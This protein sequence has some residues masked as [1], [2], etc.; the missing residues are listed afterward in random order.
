MKKEMAAKNKM[1]VDPAAVMRVSPSLPADGNSPS[2]EA[3]WWSQVA[4][5]ITRDVAMAIKD[6][7][8]NSTSVTDSPIKNL[9]SLDIPEDFSPPTGVTGGAS[10]AAA[11]GRGAID[12]SAEPTA[13]PASGGLPDPT[14]PIP[15]GPPT[16]PT[17]RVS[18]NLYDVVDFKMTLD[19][20]SDKVDLFLKTLATN[21]F[22]TVTRVEM[23]PVDSQLKQIQWYVYGTH[24]VVTLD[25]D[26]E[27]LF[28]R[29]WT[30][31]WMPSS[32]RK[33]LG[34]PDVA[35]GGKTAS[36]N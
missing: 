34:I 18:T 6:V 26:C 28:M 12:P 5:W 9:I 31:K 35:A 23:N 24:P 14:I 11:G 19:I 33:A 7:N 32:L 2:K 21:R 36:V 27:A 30:I 13:T 8:A 22:I 1:Y 25:L 15:D 4:F 3:I 10:A 16:V 17:R 29:Q 20:E